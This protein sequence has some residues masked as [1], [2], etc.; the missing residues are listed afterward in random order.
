MEEQYRIGSMIDPQRI[1]LAHSNSVSRL[2]TV[3][4]RQDM[5]DSG[6]GVLE[7]TPLRSA[8]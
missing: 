1:I 5:H 7:V 8:I 3:E 2:T 4:N 6:P